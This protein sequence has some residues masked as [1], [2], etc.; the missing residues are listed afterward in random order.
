MKTY[1]NLFEK[2]CSFENIHLA[3][4]QA[5]KCK[6]YRN[7]ILEFSYNLEENLLRIQQELLNQTYQHGGYRKFTVCDSKK[8]QIKAPSFP[9]RV[10]H[11]ALCNIIEP[12]FDK[13][14]I[15]DSYA[16]RKGKGTHGAIKRLEKFWRSTPDPAGGRGKK[17]FCLTCD[18]SKYFD[19]I[20]HKILLKLIKK[21]ITVGRTLWL[22]EKILNSSEEKPGVGI[23]IGNLTSQLFANIYLNELDQFVKHG[24]RARYYIRYMDDFLI[25]DFDKREL[26]QIK[27]EIR[28]FLK[29][30]LNLELHPKKANIFPVEKGIAFLG[31]QIFGTH[32]LLRKSTVKKFIKRTKFYQRRLREGLMSP[33]KFNQSLQSWLSYTGFGKSWRLRKNLSERLGVK[34]IK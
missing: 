15:F 31:Y 34:L 25:L 33:E 1:N 2:L 12:L 7:N 29:N 18:I 11:H 27:K 19:S 32:R 23:P 8:R 13:G 14:F 5:R 4:L 22:I 26:R 16:C 6:R 3:Y 10:I 17:K 30:K 28:E 9:D 20:D 21:K 24:L